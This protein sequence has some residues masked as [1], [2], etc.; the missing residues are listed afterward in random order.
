MDNVFVLPDNQY[1]RAVDPV[2]Q[3]I[4][5]A[6]HYLSIK[7]GDAFE[8]CLKW[9]Q[10]SIKQ[11]SFTGI[12]DPKIVF[13]ERGDNEDRVKQEC[14][15]SGYIY[16][17][18]KQDLIIAPTLTCYLPP[19]V[20]KSLLV[21][22]VKDN[23][24]GRSVAKKLW[25]KAL[26]EGDKVNTVI[27]FIEQTNRKL[28]NNA[29]SGA[30]CVSSSPVFNRTAHSTLTSNCRSVTS[31]ANSNNEKIIT[32]NR[33]YWRYDIVINNIISITLN[34]DYDKLAS[35]MTKF[36]LHVPTVDD[37]M[38]CITYSTSLY[39][40]DH[41]HSSKI[42]TL[43]ASLNPLQRAAFVYTSDLYH[44]KK[45]NDSFIRNF[46]K[47]LSSRIT[48]PVHDGLTKLKTIPEDIMNLAHQL[49]LNEVRGKGKKYDKMH[50]DGTL[51]VVVATALN[52]ITTLNEYKDLIQTFF[53]TSNLP[54]SIALM[55]TSIRRAVVT[56]DTDSTIFSV[57]DWASWY[58]GSTDVNDTSA[59]VAASIVFFT[60]QS[61]THLLAT[62]SVNIGFSPES[63]HDMAMKSE[64]FWPVFVNTSVAKHYTGLCSVQEGNVYD[65]YKVEI[66]GVHLMSSNTPKAIIDGAHTMLI[67]MMQ[68]IL[69]NK[70]ISLLDKL[71]IVAN[72]ERDIITSL[73][74]GEMEFYRSGKI[75]ESE[76]YTKTEVLS[77]YQHYLM[78]VD[79]MAPKYGAIAPPPYGVIKIPT[80]MNN[81]TAIAD[82]LDN[83]VDQDLK[84]RL[85]S[86]LL[87]FGKDSLPTMYLSTDYVVSNGIPVEITPVIDVRRIV[88]DLCNIYYIILECYGY[89]VKEGTII[90][91]FY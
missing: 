76:A 3:Y 22:Y 18:I 85:A 81:K 15:L 31:H 62:L 19:K 14:S 5:Q 24:K 78:W 58:I 44:I 67:D 45:F 72:L 50:E 23:I 65:K 25:F 40:C 87:K 17:A 29:L 49:C 36:N 80:I 90:S 13:Y 46:I 57:Q 33:H 60:S 39:W 71:T 27:K 30:H 1:V 82:W 83:M 41:N 54:I 70:K 73:L 55:P 47:S 10:D 84:Q 4:N 9:V 69:D 59:A 20:K 77:P 37:V 42:K 16:S 2:G 34:T 6:A 26:S 74:K 12:K 89:Y 53:T 51:G 56:S 32:G 91:D 86:W 11:K 43:V 35:T 7:S 38:D 64:F 28:S 75:K 63:L 8:T 79:V 52:I 48:V 88:A 21:G 66:K 61:I 68:N